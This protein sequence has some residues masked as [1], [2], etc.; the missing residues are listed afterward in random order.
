MRAR[1]DELFDERP[2][3]PLERVGR[4]RAAAGLRDG[5]ARDERTD[6]PSGLLA[7]R[8]AQARPGCRRLLHTHRQAAARAAASPPL[9]HAGG[10]RFE[11][12]TARA[13]R[14]A[15]RLAKG[16]PCLSERGAGGLRVAS[17]ER[18]DGRRDLAVAPLLGRL[19][20]RLGRASPS[21]KKG[22]RRRGARR[23]KHLGHPDE[24]V[25]G[26][27]ARSLL[28]E[29]W[30]PRHL[31]EQSWRR[32]IGRGQRRGRHTDPAICPRQDRRCVPCPAA[33]GIGR[34]QRTPAR[35]EIARTGERGRRAEPERGD[36]GKRSAVRQRCGDAVA[37]NARKAACG[38]KASQRSAEPS[39][40]RVEGGVQA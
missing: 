25:E 40:D 36:R 21:P 18:G 20:L 16:R 3:D 24:Q 7:A 32:R 23:R 10:Q 17:Q 34:D 14:L 2:R 26:A 13:H 33:S 5:P 11:H 28:F 35:M 19:R 37:E 8:L 12:R 38:E 31:G 39:V 6:H 27:E 15:A 22:P 29:R 30:R 1:A 9:L 4:E